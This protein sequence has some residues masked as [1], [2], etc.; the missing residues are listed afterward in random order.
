MDR[1]LSGANIAAEVFVRLLTFSN[2]R[3]AIETGLFNESTRFRMNKLEQQKSELK[4]RLAA[5][6]LKEDLGLKEEDIVF[7]LHQFWNMDCSDVT[8]QKW[9]I[10]TFI[11]SV[12]V[13]GIRPSQAKKQD[14]TMFKS[15]NLE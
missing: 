2:E 1:F 6:K 10:K 15:I 4:T 12:F 9:L 5:A 11:N 13:Y 3:R 8:C 14:L 7:F